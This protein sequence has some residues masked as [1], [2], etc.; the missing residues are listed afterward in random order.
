[1]TLL[2]NIRIHH[3]PPTQAT[4]LLVQSLVIFRLDYCNSLHAGLPLSTIRPIQLIRNAAAWFIFNLLSHHHISTLPSL[5]SCSSQHQIQ[6]TDA[7]LQSQKWTYLIALI[8]LCT[9]SH[10]LRSSSTAWQVPSS[11]RVQ[12][13]PAFR[14]FTVSAP[15]W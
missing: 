13:R 10:S 4:Q 14:L 1:M 8:T 5:A 15:R 11:L 2:F 7:C 9:V 6:N 3:F 12:R